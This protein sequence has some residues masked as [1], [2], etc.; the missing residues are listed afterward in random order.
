MY[1]ASLY[2]LYNVQT[3][4]HLIGSFIILSFIYRS[5]MFQGQRVF[6]R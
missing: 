2:Y 6:L 1:R 4:A 5:Y 3:K